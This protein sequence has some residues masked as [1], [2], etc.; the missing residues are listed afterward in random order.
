M[1]LKWSNVDTNSYLKVTRIS[2][3]GNLFQAPKEGRESEGEKTRR[4][5]GETRL[6]FPTAP[7]SPGS[8]ASII[9]AFPFCSR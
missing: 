7:F 1:Q 8:R 3:Q 4:D 6:P 5:W 9:F 2:S